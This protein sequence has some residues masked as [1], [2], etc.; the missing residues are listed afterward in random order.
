MH[1]A[2]RLL[3]PPLRHGLRIRAK[4]GVAGLEGRSLLCIDDFSSDE[5]K[6]LIN[7]SVDL[8]AM[9]ANNTLPK[10]LERKIIPMIF[11]KRSTR[12]RLSTE[13]GMAKLGGTAIMLSA[14]D[15][16]LGVNE[17]LL[18]SARV[19]SR[20]G[21]IILARVYGHEDV[22]VL[23]N[24]S[25]VPVINALSDLHHPLQTLADYMTIQERFGSCEGLTLSWVGDGNNVLHD[26]MLAAPKLGVNLQIGTPTGFEPDSG[27]TSRTQELAAE[28]GTSI[29]M[30]TDPKEA[31]NGADI[32]VTDTWVSM[33][34]EEE[35]A[36]KIKAFAGYQVTNDLMAGT[37]D[38]A[39]FMH[40]LPRHPEEVHDEVFYSD[41]SVVFDEA[42]NRM[43]TVMAVM[44]SF[45]GK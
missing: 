44:I 16:Q 11:Q 12:T 24:E 27:V 28:F 22:T 29:M 43:W 35:A 21:D 36:R 3:A 41:R 33:G 18:D 34:E 45:L 1:A 40:C 9:E 2:K 15:I 32:V 30:T 25:T 10:I 19:I 14:D 38:G 5:L 39:I 26:L 31:T 20:F 23:A 8:K 42:E 4:S 13:S 17:T 7:L 37:N 6:A